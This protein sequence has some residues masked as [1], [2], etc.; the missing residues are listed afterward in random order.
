MALL[1][2]ALGV[3]ALILLGAA[4]W[5]L[6]KREIPDAFPIALLIWAVAS[7]LLGYQ[8]PIWWRLGAGAAAG[9]LL[10]LLLFSLGWMGGGDGK[11][12]AGFGAVLGPVGL[13]A[14]LP[15]IALY[16]GVTALVGRRHGNVE[17]PYG[18]AIAIG[19]V[20]AILV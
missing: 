15:W 16:G 3:P 20:T 9:F 18:P 7:R 1:S 17:V 19:Y 6:A 13:L 10:G 8:E 4:V 11:L 5:D 14:V 12:L 2:P